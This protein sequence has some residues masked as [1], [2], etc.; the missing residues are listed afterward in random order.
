MPGLAAGCWV[1]SVL[2]EASLEAEGWEGCKVARGA[3]KAEAVAVKVANL[4]VES[5]VVVEASTEKSV[6]VRAWV[7]ATAELDLPP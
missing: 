6:D 2:S 3:A 7:V 1:A 4:D 5:L